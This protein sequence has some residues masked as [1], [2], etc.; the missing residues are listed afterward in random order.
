MHRRSTSGC[1]RLWAIG[2]GL[3]LAGIILTADLGLLPAAR[4]LQHIPLA[5]KAGH[6][7]LFGVMNLLVILAVRQSHR[8]WRGSVVAAGCTLGLIGAAA[9]EELS[10]LYIRSR[11]FS[12]LDLAAAACGIVGFG[13]VGMHFR[14]NTRPGGESR[15]HG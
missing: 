11:T 6:F 4:Q 14:Y 5:D 8:N 10:Q 2:F 7:V 1:V 12:L 9:A 13:L 3:L 15:D